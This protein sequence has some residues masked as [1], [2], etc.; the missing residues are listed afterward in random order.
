MNKAYRVRIIKGSRPTLSDVGG[1]CVAGCVVCEG[2]VVVS[3]R[4]AFAC[5]R[6][7]VVAFRLCSRDCALLSARFVCLVRSA[8]SRQ[9]PVAQVC[10]RVLAGTGF[11]VGGDPPAEPAATGL[12]VW[13][14]E[15]SPSLC[16]SPPATRSV[17]QRGA[18]GCSA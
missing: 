1:S 16:C 10:K 14:S 13:P 3:S 11:G 8:P 2:G 12:L 18:L 15:S 17:P 5:D 7:V 4:V 9:F 6:P